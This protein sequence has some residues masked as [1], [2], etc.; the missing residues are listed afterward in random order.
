MA[1]RRRSSIPKKE[2][3]PEVSLSVTSA[4]VNRIIM[5]IMTAGGEVLKS[6]YGFNEE[7]LGEWAQKTVRQAKGYLGLTKD[8]GQKTKDEGRKTMDEG[9]RTDDRGS[10]EAQADAE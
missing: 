7:Q 9:R 8:E 3:S 1:R 6:D 4:Y 5:A 10:A 2:Q